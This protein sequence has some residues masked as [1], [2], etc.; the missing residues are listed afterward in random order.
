SV[1]AVGLSGFVVAMMSPIRS[2]PGRSTP[3]RATVLALCVVRASGPEDLVGG[4]EDAPDA[5][6]GNLLI[7]EP[8]LDV[9]A[10]VRGAV[11]AERL[12]AEQRHGLRLDFLEVAGQLGAL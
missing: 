4:P 6:L 10:G 2:G 1:V 7:P 5:G 8:A 9:A 12:G 11:E 3:A